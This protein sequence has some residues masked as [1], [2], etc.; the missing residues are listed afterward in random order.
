M[1]LTFLC[2]LVAC[3]S[4][5][6]QH[7]A[8]PASP[9]SG[10][11]ARPSGPVAPRP[12]QG[13]S[14]ASTPSESADEMP[15]LADSGPVPSVP[16]PSPAA[17]QTVSG[18]AV[19]VASARLVDA[20]L[21]AIDALK[22]VETEEAG[23]RLAIA[24]RIRNDSRDTIYRGGVFASLAACFSKACTDRDSE[25]R[26]FVLPLSG[27][28]P[29]LPGRWRSFRVVTRPF[30][31]VYSEMQPETSS[32]AIHGDLRGALGGRWEGV[33]LTGIRPW[34]EASGYVTSETTPLGR[35]VAVS[36]PDQLLE[37]EDGKREWTQPV[38]ATEPPADPAALST[39]PKAIKGVGLTL[40]VRSFRPVVVE[41]QGD[42]KA[43]D[44]YLAVEVALTQYGDKPA[45]CGFASEVT[46]G[47]R[48]TRRPSSKVPPELVPLSCS[49]LD[50]GASAVGYLVFDWPRGARPL[51]AEFTIP[52]FPP[53]RLAVPVASFWP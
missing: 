49:K 44:R 16:A 43:D 2:L 5:S 17:V 45:S 52:K 14:V 33:L 9:S 34:S 7:N 13:S 28:D 32:Y 42:G 10:G 23:T 36:G 29:W 47:R 48:L 31:P 35:V 38:H 4:G 19:E 8:S 15:V 41:R 30:D 26:G 22:G 40:E 51:W 3:T 25:G 21:H 46:F 24:G 18:F 39:L 6:S 53:L 37:T 20:R 12:Q 1:R 11:N 27:G 50:V